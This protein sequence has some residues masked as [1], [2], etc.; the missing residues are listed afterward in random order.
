MG[1][2]IHE[3]SP[4]APSTSLLSSASIPGAHR[5]PHPPLHFE[6]SSSLTSL[7]SGSTLTPVLCLQLS[8]SLHATL[9]LVSHF[10]TPLLSLIQ[11]SPRP[12]YWLCV[13]RP[14]TAELTGNHVQ[15]KVTC[16]CPWRRFVSPGL[17]VSRVTPPERGLCL[18]WVMRHVE[19]TN[20]RLVF[21]FHKLKYYEQR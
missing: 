4:S 14:C 6:L 21:R 13:V 18:S 10:R 15:I 12:L 9:E 11:R 8:D 3:T 20:G 7:H 19:K 1:A 16:S 5:E 17:P 2:F